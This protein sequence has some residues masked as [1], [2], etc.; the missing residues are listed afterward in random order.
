MYRIAYLASKDCSD[1][2]ASSGVHFYQSAALAKHCAEVVFLGPVNSPIINLIRKTFNFLHRFLPKKYNHSHSIA[3]SK[4]YGIIFSEKL[5]GG[6]YDFIFADKASCEIAFLITK[7]P[8][9]YST[10]ATFSLLN[11]YY[12]GYS[13][14]FG[15]SVNESKSIE[16]NAINLSSLIICTSKWA[17]DSVVNQYNFPADRVH[18]LP[19]GA[20]IDAVPD[21]EVVLGKRKTDVC[22]LIF[23]G[24]DHQRKGFDIAYRTMEYIRSKNI[25]V[26]LLAVGCCPPA[27]F[28]DQDVEIMGYI[29]KN[30]LEGMALFDKLM[31]NSDFFLQPT[32]AECMGIVFCESAAYGLPVITT[33]TGG[34]REV[35]KDGINGYALN[36]HA[37]H[38]EY[39]EK[40][41]SIFNSE[42][43]YYNLIRSSRYYFEKRLN[44]DTWGIS[45]KGILDKYMLSQESIEP[46]P[47][48]LK[49]SIIIPGK[50]VSPST[51]NP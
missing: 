24:K 46:P 11:N 40:I 47:T 13:N 12:A 32:R 37:D 2:G 29:D 19:R 27:Q 35:V 25:A 22:R 1:R 6:K 36:Y 26:K 49:S 28:S 33:D 44:W 30:T 48:G 7:I 34:V 45:M 16:Q 43:K 4:I 50:I 31:L 38:R 51:L 5:A 9:I 42:K 20:N 23:V 15:F 18:V 41:I 21:R 10:D 17:A 3:I 14:L 39:G 8:V